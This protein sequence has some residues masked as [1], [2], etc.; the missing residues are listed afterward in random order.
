[1]KNE[2][3]L[4]PQHRLRKLLQMIEL[5]KPPGRTLRQLVS[6]FDMS[7]KTMRRYLKILDEAGFE[8]EQDFAGRHFIIED[9]AE[10]K[11]VRLTADEIVLIS[12]LLGQAATDN[13][14]SQNILGK[15]LFRT[16][17]GSKVKFTYRRNAPEVIAQ[18]SEAMR[19]NKQVE[20]STYFSASTGTKRSRTIQPLGFTDNFNYLLAYEETSGR[21]NNLKMFRIHGVRILEKSCTVSPDIA[22]RV[23]VFQMAANGEY[24]PV[25]LL[26]NPLAYHLLTEEYPNTEKHI[27]PSGDIDFP[28]RFSAVLHNFLPVGRFYL[29]LPGSIV[30]EGP[31]ALKTYLRKK[32]RDFIL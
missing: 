19:L 22:G 3:N 25:S 28:Y 1:M 24:H 16:E 17:L 4:A 23:D 26:L 2:T 8:M 31:D 11:Q 20:I 9:I 27:T 5:L 6:H 13:P 32:K 21:V 7:A 14:L 10:G 12:D 29:G 30:V 15:L 18:L